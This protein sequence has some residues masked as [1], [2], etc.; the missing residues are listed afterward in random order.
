MRLRRHAG[1]NA[2]R[3]QTDRP[4]HLDLGS[5]V[6]QVGRLGTNLHRA[7]R[8]L[9]VRLGYGFD[10]QLRV[11]MPRVPHHQV[12]LTSLG[13]CAAVKHDDVVADLKR[14]RQIVRDVHDRH[15]VLLIQ[16]AQAVENSGA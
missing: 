14:G 2:R 13:H 10:Q 3:K 12:H 16:L 8:V 1:G 7:P 15:A 11:R 4:A 6:L 9:G 5:T